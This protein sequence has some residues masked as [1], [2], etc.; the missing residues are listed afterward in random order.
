MGSPISKRICCRFGC[1]Q[2]LWIAAACR[3]NDV[4]SLTVM[5]TRHVWVRNRDGPAC[6]DL[7]FE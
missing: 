3:T 5:K 4:A 7:P 6:R 2:Y 1:L